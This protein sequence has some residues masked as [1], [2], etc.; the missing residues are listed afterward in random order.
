MLCILYVTAVG[1]LLGVVGLLAE[2]MLPAAFARR[3]VW[4]LVIPTSIALPGYYRAHHAAMVGEVLGGTPLAALDAGWWARVA[5]YDPTVNRVWLI[6]SATL[7][8]WAVA[9]AA[10]V[11]YVVRASRNGQDGPKGL[12]VVD[13]VPVVVTDG[14]G[15]ATVGMWR[16]RVLLPRW[17]LALP[18]AQRRYVVRH[19]EEH[20]RAHDGRLLFVASLTL[21]VAPWNL[22]LWWQVR[23]LSLAIEMDCDRR[24]VR[25]LG[26]A[27]AYGELLLTVAQAASR[28][29]R[30]QPAL[31]GGMGMLERR[32]TMLLAPAPLQRMQRWLLPVIAAAILYVALVMPHPVI[33]MSHGGASA[34]PHATHRRS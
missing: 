30:L 6:V 13:G 31:L 23:R 12:A 28:G 5:S 32:L 19:E 1:A 2:R 20:R 9:S 15:P 17:A 10:R 21:L 16:T 3:T 29:P 33:S 8:L 24:V 26:D 27:R 18:Q 11:A 22:A 25:A 7:L 34:G 14:L 4:C